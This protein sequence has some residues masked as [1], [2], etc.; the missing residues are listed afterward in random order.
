[1]GKFLL[2]LQERV[3]LWTKP[4]QPSAHFQMSLAVVPI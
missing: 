1:M 4:A 3:K 2:W